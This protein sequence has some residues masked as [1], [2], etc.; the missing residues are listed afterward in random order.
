[1]DRVITIW[2]VVIAVLWI[3]SGLL[4][5]AD[6]LV[7]EWRLGSLGIYLACAASVA[8]ICRAVRSSHRAQRNA[9]ELGRDAE[10]E[11]GGVRHLRR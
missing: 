8:T 9:F 11:L 10:R 4:V 7:R 6:I 3:A 5:V 1:M 2:S